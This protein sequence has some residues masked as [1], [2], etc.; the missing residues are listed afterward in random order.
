MLNVAFLKTKLYKMK[1]CTQ[2]PLAHVKRSVMEI[3]D[4]GAPGEFVTG[5]SAL[6]RWLRSSERWLRSSPPDLEFFKRENKMK[7]SQQAGS[8]PRPQDH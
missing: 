8:N 1:Q 7:M 3:N 2:S 6:E 5:D 4:V